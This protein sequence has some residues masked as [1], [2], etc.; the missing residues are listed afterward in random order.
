MRTLHNFLLLL[1]VSLL[2]VACNQNQTKET[3]PVDDQGY[4]IL[5]PEQMEDLVKRSY[6]YVALYNVTNKFAMAQGGWNTL[7]SDTQ[8]KDHTLTDIARPNNDTFYSSALLDLRDDAMILKFPG[9]DSKYVS[10]MITAYDHYVN[11]PLTTGAGD[12]AEEGTLLIYSDHT[13][14]YDGEE[15]EGIDHYFKATGD[16]VSAVFRIMPHASDP[17]RFDKVVSQIKSIELLSLSSYQGNEDLP[18]SPVAF[19]DV[20]TSDADVFENN[21]LEVM[22]FVFNHISFDPDNSLDKAV[23]EIYKPLGIMPG[24]TYDPEAGIEVNGVELRAIAD[25]IKE[26]E[27][28]KSVD[29]DFRKKI[30]SKMFQ[31]KGE[32]DLETLLNVSILGPIGMPEEEAIYPQIQTADGQPMNAMNDYIIRMSAEELPP[33]R[34]FWS[35][36]LYDLENGFF[37]PND[38]KK[39]SVGENAGMKLND[40]GGIEIYIASEKPEGVSEENWLPIER[41]DINL[42]PTLRIYQA[43]LDVMKTWTVPFA[44]K[45]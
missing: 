3:I 27:M 43:D 32:T 44:E 20:G 39:Y 30:Q 31:P 28:K 21:L 45:L 19:P 4:A 15:L 12:F 22:Q 7:Q 37:I 26:E 6:Q 29:E 2:A 41:K 33:A 8:L 14:N 13:K 18:L 10:L 9:F 11:I 1:L 17:D 25:R 40:A 23:L 35:I 34:A 24:G 16:F 5:T 42:S 36:T 38:L